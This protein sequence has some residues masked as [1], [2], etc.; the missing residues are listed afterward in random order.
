MSGRRNQTSGLLALA[1]ALVFFSLGCNRQQDKRKAFE[2]ARGTFERGDFALARQE[3][4]AAY[5]RCSNSDKECASRLRLLEAEIAW[6]EG[7]GQD[8]L[9]LLDFQLPPHLSRS[10][11]AVKQKILQSG[12]EILLG[13]PQDANQSLTAAEALS[14]ESSPSAL[15][16]EIARNRGLLR[17]SLRDF[18]GADQFFRKSL[19]LARQEKNFYLEM[20][21]LVNLGTVFEQ[22]GHYDEAID[23]SNNAHQI[24]QTLHDR[25]T[26]EETLGNQAWA[27]YKMGDFDRALKLDTEAEATAGAVAAE[28]DQISWLNNLGLVLFQQNQFSAAESYY[29]RSLA[30]AQKI[31]APQTIIDA[32]TS[33]A[34]VSV[35]NGNPSEA[36]NYAEEAFRMAHASND[37]ASELPTIL[38]KGQVLALQGNQGDAERL[39]SEVAHDEKSDLSLRWQAQNDLAGLY[40]RAGRV[41][42][43]DRQYREALATIERARASLQH[44]DFKLPF[45]ANAAHLYDDYVQF[46]VSQKKVDAA[47]QFADYSRARTLTEG[48]EFSPKSSANSAKP[49][50][51]AFDAQRIAR[52]ANATVLFYWL[53]R[54]Q[55]YLWAV[56]GSRTML[57]PL[58]PA[59][60]IDAAVQ[61]Y[62]KALLG[63]QNVLQNANPDGKYLYDV[64]LAPARQLIPQNSRVVVVADGTLNTLNFETLLAPSPQLHYWIEDAT[65]LSAS[66]LRVLE[67]SQSARQK[68]SGKLLLIGDALSTDPDFAPLPNAT[69]EMSSIAK[70]FKVESTETYAGDRA[71]PSAYLKSQPERF[72]FIHFVAHARASESDPLDSAIILSPPSAELDAFK[73]YARDIKLLPLRADLV[74]ISS[75]NS[76]GTKGYTGEGLVGL[77]WAFLRA[78]A[79]NVIGALWEVDD[80]STATLM[81]RLYDELEKGHPPDESLRSAKLSLLHSEDVVRKPFYWAPFQLYTGR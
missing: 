81:D 22:Q 71:V 2:R 43:A 60:E 18:E 33:L 20:A 73:L 40:Q 52:R 67:A 11:L 76:V 21:D 36:Q 29:R 12:A 44:E 27:Y 49:K 57:Y 45:L 58:P 19:T 1:S 70:H 50:A 63:W 41:A 35:Q 59:Q 61:R 80:A 77:S 79:H 37:R 55:S 6:N 65:I 66:S 69:A 5:R 56:T 78:G 48:L 42:D 17:R 47:L 38:V 28:A 13:R 4:D 8:A 53:G 15:L 30:L 23:W 75:C 26:E 68:G 74:T 25:S 10:D 3:A 34:F 16:G 46:L 51:E 54:K 7:L 72:S 14:V 32:L 64:L 9:F 39:F 24:A 62:R 31:Q